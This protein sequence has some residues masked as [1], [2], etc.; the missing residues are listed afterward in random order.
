[1]YYVNP[2][3]LSLEG[4]PEFLT[5]VGTSEERKVAER[6]GGKR[7]ALGADRAHGRALRH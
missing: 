2:V 7:G 5:E 6:L 3:I 4:Y 1:M